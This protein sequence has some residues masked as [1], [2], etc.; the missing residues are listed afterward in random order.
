VFVA[1]LSLS[2]RVAAQEAET[3]NDPPAAEVAARQA[4]GTQREL[5]AAAVAGSDDQGPDGAA[6]DPAVA[7]DGRG[8]QGLKA[9][10]VDSDRL[11]E[12]AVAAAA[13]PTQTRALTSGDDKSGVT[14]K[15]I[16]V[17]KGSG[18]VQG[19]EESFS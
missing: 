16:S 13:E 10:A 12:Q 19:M 17:P 7:S 1:S 14:S 5:G 2:Q 11:K 6:S 9:D 4:I 8:D 15:A 18:T 3:R